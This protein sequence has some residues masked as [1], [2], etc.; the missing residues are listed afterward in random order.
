MTTQWVYRR[1]HFRISKSGNL[2][3]VRS[4][5]ALCGKATSKLHRRGGKKCPVRGAKIQSVH[6]PNGSWAHFEGARG[7]GRMKHPCLHIGER[8]VPT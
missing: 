8:E 3:F 6:M 1:A 5:S 4:S 7:L 2:V